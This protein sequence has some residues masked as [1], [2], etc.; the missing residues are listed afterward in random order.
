M[1]NGWPED[2]G[3]FFDFGNI[4][5]ADLAAE[6][7]IVETHKEGISCPVMKSALSHFVSLRTL[8]PARLTVFDSIFPCPRENM[9]RLSCIRA[10][11]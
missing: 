2:V 8:F 10:F 11:V 3:V 7:V 5:D 6:P 9:P 1:V 4:G